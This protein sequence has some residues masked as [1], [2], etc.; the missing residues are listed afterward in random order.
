MTRYGRRGW[1]RSSSGRRTVRGYTLRGRNGRINYVGVTNNPRRRAA[2]HRQNGKLGW[3]KV[4][5]WPMSREAGDSWEAGRLAVY[6]RY[7]GG[8]NPPQNKTRSGGWER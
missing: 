1:N 4:E 5:N 8:K 3:M 2:E 7:H 6:R